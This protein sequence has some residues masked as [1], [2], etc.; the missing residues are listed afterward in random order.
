MKGPTVKNFRTITAAVAIAATAFI[1]GHN[2][3]TADQPRQSDA[4]EYV[5]IDQYRALDTRTGFRPPAGNAPTISTGL[6]DESGYVTAAAVAVNITVTDTSGAGYVT[7]WSE[8]LRP[9]TSVLT[10]DRA[11]DTETGFAIVPLNPQGEFRVFVSMDA[12]VIVDVVGAI[13]AGPNPF[14]R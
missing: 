7:A 3:A 12:H 4:G 6:V 11:G 8:G 5:V 9:D 13:S 1:A 2:G 10:I 14:A